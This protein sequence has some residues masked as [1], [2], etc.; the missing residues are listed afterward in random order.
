LHSLELGLSHDLLDLFGGQ[1]RLELV[2]GQLI[3]LLLTDVE[4]DVE[5]L[6]LLSILRLVV[7]LH[8]LEEVFTALFL[9][10]IL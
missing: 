7:A 3:A 2:I 5:T 1:L 6:D 10:L 9:S 4:R 8:H